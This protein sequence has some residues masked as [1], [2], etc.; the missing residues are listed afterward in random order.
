MGI[1]RARAGIGLTALGVVLMAFGVG[2]FLGFLVGNSPAFAAR[3]QHDALL[4]L[5]ERHANEAEYLAR[6]AIVGISRVQ[7]QRR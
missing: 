1:D 2:G 5:T 4:E 6:R 3:P 7:K